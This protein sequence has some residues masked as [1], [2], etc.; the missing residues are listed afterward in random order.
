MAKSCHV[1]ETGARPAQG[2]SKFSGGQVGRQHPARRRNMSN[3]QRLRASSEDDQDV[4]ES[5]DSR[6]DAILS[7]NAPHE[8]QIQ[9]VP[10]T[11][12]WASNAEIA[13]LLISSNMNSDSLHGPQLQSTS[14]FNFWSRSDTSI[15]LDLNMDSV[16]FS[17]FDL[18]SPE[19]TTTLFQ[20]AILPN[21]LCDLDAGEQFGAETTIGDGLPPPTTAIPSQPNL[22]LLNEMTTES[23]ENGKWLSTLAELNVKL[24]SH[25]KLMRAHACTPDQGAQSL[26]ASSA[27][28]DDALGLFLQFIGLLQHRTVVSHTPS[29]SSSIDGSS[30]GTTSSNGFGSDTASSSIAA[31]HGSV[32]MMLSCYIRI[33]ETCTKI[34]TAI[35]AALST[36]FSS[37]ARPVPV[38]RLSIGSNALENQYPLIRLRVI[39][40]LIESLLDSMRAYLAPN[41]EVNSGG[42]KQFEE[43]AKAS[44]DR[45]TFRQQSQLTQQANPCYLQEDKAFELIRTIRIDLRQLQGDSV[46]AA[47]GLSR[48]I[49]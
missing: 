2:D 21:P 7:L 40:E 37:N 11:T 18:A 45:C 17:D 15:D 4:G 10:D 23:M 39:I 9:P 47:L 19:R 24:F 42:Q 30:T 38:L 5:N 26:Y 6:I 35:K 13:N 12:S 8:V 41:T 49:P 3:T 46:A 43:L 34:L 48:D 22:E 31:D 28:L 20:K 1:N 33:L 36:G 14:L 25:A 27:M 16:D 32:L 44:W 29:L